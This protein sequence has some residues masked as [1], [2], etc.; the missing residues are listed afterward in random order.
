MP[1]SSNDSSSA[2]SD[3][4]HNVI[5]R[6][7]QSSKRIYF[8]GLNSLRF[9]AASFVLVHHVEQIKS[10]QGYD[11]YF[12]NIFVHSIGGY[13][14]TFF[15][16]LSGFLITYLLLVEQKNTNT[17][18]IKKFYIRRVLRIWP[19][20]YLFAI[21]SLVILPQIQ[22]LNIPVWQN[23]LEQNYFSQAFL[24]LTFLPNIALSFLGIIPH[25]NQVWSI[26]VEE[27]FYLIWPLIVRFS[28]NIWQASCKIIGAY[29]F[30][31]LITLAIVQYQGDSAQYKYLLQW[32]ELMQYTRIDCM[33][34]GAVG[35]SLLYY[36][37][38]YLQPF[39][40]YTS[41]YFLYTVSLL[42][43]A[44]GGIKG[45]VLWH[46]NQQIFAIFSIL[47][48]LNIATNPKSLFK[49]EN[50]TLDYL[51]RISYGL[52]MYHSLCIAIA[53]YLVNQFSNYSISSFMGNAIV[54]PLM[55]LMTIG[56]AAVSYHWIEQPFI[57]QKHKFAKVPSG[58]SPN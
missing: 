2:Q 7:D 30:I 55:L 53:I 32:S 46:F 15:F 23:E 9:I 4:E 11:N 37:R 41:Q 58:S 56:F 45:G 20:Y 35:A 40:S 24:Y 34:I 21:L 33:A 12:D 19:L 31:K 28:R 54:Y 29:L 1:Y 5:S 6:Q 38:Q 14:V 22:A 50:K 26:G 52:Y 43:L 44:V 39:Y 3:R 17:I 10:T 47:I 49:L 51:G 13:S 25:A 42:F 48:I 27:Q 57:R 8:P 16:V 18:D 36:H